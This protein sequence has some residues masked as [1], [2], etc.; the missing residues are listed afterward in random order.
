MLTNIDINS[1][2]IASDEDR[3]LFACLM[4]VCDQR[5]GHFADTRWTSKI[6]YHLYN[7][8]R[9]LCDSGRTE[10]GSRDIR[11]TKHIVVL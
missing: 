7:R 4:L 8:C 5:C 3:G 6:I 9:L 11:R 1:A 2:T 10:V